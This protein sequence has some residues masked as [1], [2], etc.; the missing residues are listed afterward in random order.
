MHTSAQPSGFYSQYNGSTCNSAYQNL[1]LIDN[2]KLVRTNDYTKNISDFLFSPCLHEVDKKKRNK[3]KTQNKKSA[4]TG[5]T[6]SSQ[7]TPNK[8]MFNT[9]TKNQESTKV[10]YMAKVKASTLEKDI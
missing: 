6:N 1:N 4:G 3:T 8:N 2:V 7:K 10:K 9:P 5:S